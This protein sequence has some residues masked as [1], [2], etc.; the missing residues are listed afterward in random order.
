M[1][2]EEIKIPL[3]D[4]ITKSYQNGELRSSQKQAVITL[5]EKMTRTRN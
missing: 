5:I 1:F 2:W 4:N 3:H